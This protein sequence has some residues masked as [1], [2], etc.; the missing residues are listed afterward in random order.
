MSN[1]YN[2]LQKVLDHIEVNI[3]SEMTLD[4]LAGLCHY[5]SH[6]FH[7]VFQS[8]VG[9][10]VMDYIKKRKLSIASGEIIDTNKS[11]LDIAL[12]YSFSSNETFSRAFK[13]A[14][15]ITPM[16]Y[17]KM[18]TH[19]IPVDFW[20]V[21][22]ANSDIQRRYMTAV[23]TLV[24]RLKKDKNILG[25]I[26]FGSLSYDKVWEKSDIDM[27]IVVNDGCKLSGGLSLMED[28]IY[29]NGGIYTRSE[30]KQFAGKIN[31]TSGINSYY[32]LGTMVYCRDPALKEIFEE[33]CRIGERD[34]YNA[35]I[36]Q[37]SLVLTNL[38]KAE[39]WLKIKSDPR[40]SYLWIIEV[41]KHLSS[42]EV[43]LNDN[44]PNREV[45]HQALKYNHPLIEKLYIK[46]MDERKNSINLSS[47]VELVYDYL[48][49]HMRVICKP[50]LDYFEEVLEPKPLTVIVKDFSN[51]LWFHDICEVCEWLCDEQILA[52]D[53]SEIR[54][55]KKSNTVVYEPAYVM[56]SDE[57]DL[58]I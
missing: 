6:H 19:A 54:I 32:S 55:T 4:E 11:I 51:R 21:S 46:L 15:D 34:K 47:S 40:Y 5:S 27:S 48:R 17:R 57:V 16:T 37:T 7:R 12:S 49:E 14:F 36:K 9:V 8:V 1:Y 35:L 44:I 25:V 38:Y 18:N 45:I 22:F 58:I 2:E 23:E 43:I 33:M 13:R 20:K 10:P 39:K 24:G 28:E 29:V 30:F 56:N 42:I 41:L 52:K 26:V 53:I 3:K 31:Q 50:I